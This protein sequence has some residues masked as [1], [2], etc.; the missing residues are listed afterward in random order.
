MCAYALHTVSQDLLNPYV[1]CCLRKLAALQLMSPR[2]KSEPLAE[3]QVVVLRG[4]KAA[5]LN[6]ALGRVG[7]L[8]DGRYAVHLLE[9][10]VRARLD[11]LEVGLIPD[12]A[13]KL[14][15]GQLVLVHSLTSEVGRLLN[16]CVG[17]I[18]RSELVD[19]RYA[20]QLGERGLHQLRP[21]NLVVV[22][23]LC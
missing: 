17:T 23:A 16:C 20:V 14:E 4:L 7:A 10:G 9:R 3:G 8:D 11:N 5:V 22:P 19:N 6:G 21:Q 13:M 1:L 15:K 12:E 18:S 2:E